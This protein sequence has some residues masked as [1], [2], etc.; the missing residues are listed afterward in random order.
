[1]KLKLTVHPILRLLKMAQ[2][3]VYFTDVPRLQRNYRGTPTKCRQ[4][5][6]SSKVI[7]LQKR[8]MNLFGSN[9][10]LLVKF[11]CGYLSGSCDILTYVVSADVTLQCGG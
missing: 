10:N 5:S 8:I 4:D 3:L 9:T 11:S 1:M 7:S 6:L 2:K